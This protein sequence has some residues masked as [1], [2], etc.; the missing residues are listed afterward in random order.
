V[1]AVGGGVVPPDTATVRGK[2][3]PARCFPPPWSIEETDACFI[4]RDD[5]GQALA[6]DLP[7]GERPP[8][9]SPANRHSHVTTSQYHELSQEERESTRT[10]R[11]ATAMTSPIA[12]R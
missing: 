12:S 6:Y 2:W 11:P 9:S 10:P 5:N 8:S 4:I 7:A 1:V 3:M